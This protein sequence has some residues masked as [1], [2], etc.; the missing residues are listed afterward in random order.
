VQLV[1]KMFV[2]TSGV[3]LT[4]TKL[5]PEGRIV[6]GTETD[7]T[8]HPYQVW[9]MCCCSVWRYFEV[10]EQK[11]P[12]V[13]VMKKSFLSKHIKNCWLNRRKLVILYCYLLLH[14]L[15]RSFIAHW[16]IAS[17]CLTANSWTTSMYCRKR[18]HLL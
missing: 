8:S 4:S 11:R 1:M 6:G 12:A 5:K 9:S 15:H 7:I 10:F 13:L 14:Q 2:N 18:N 3:S 17:N 16:L